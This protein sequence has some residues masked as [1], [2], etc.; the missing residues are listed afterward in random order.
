MK[1]FCNEMLGRVGRGLRAA[2]YVRRLPR[3]ASATLRSL[4]AAS[5]R[6]AG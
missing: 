4:R 3:A 5:P 2:G 1:L 6:R